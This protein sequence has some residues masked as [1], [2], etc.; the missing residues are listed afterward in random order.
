MIMYR[1]FLSLTLNAMPMV[2]PIKI[3]TPTMKYADVKQSLKDCSMMG[4]NIGKNPTNTCH[5]TSKP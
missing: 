3:M 2:E 5:K 4:L 1:T